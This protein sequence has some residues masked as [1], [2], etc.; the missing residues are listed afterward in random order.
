MKIFISRIDHERV[1]IDK[2][3]KKA[4]YLCNMMGGDSAKHLFLAKCWLGETKLEV[5]MI[6]PYF[7]AIDKGDI[8]KTKEVY[9]SSINYQNDVLVAV[10]EMRMNIGELELAIKGIMLDANFSKYSYSFSYLV[11]S[12]NELK[13]ARFCY[14]FQLAEIREKTS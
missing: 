2:L 7:E 8:P 3:I 10:N 12:I 13:K 9:D 14:G 11:K 6:T 4:N 5:G 1:A